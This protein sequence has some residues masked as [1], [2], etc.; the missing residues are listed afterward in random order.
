MTLGKLTETEKK[1]DCPV[2]PSVYHRSLLL[3]ASPPK[4]IWIVAL[5][6]LRSYLT[7]LWKKK[8]NWKS[9]KKKMPTAWSI[10]L[11]VRACGFLLL[12]INLTS[13]R[14]PELPFCGLREILQ[15]LRLTGKMG[16]ITG[17]FHYILFELSLYTTTSTGEMRLPF[18]IHSMLH[19]TP[20]TDLALMGDDWYVINWLIDV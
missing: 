2:Q 12:W 15:Y 17:F 10:L 3:P 4:N 19:T 8:K 9:N 14:E 16:L 11:A 7:S 18:P 13:S 6:E 5:G 1:C 20:H